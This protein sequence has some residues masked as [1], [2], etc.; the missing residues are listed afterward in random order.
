[1]TDWS[2]SYENIWRIKFKFLALTDRS[3]KNKNQDAENAG[4]I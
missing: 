2:F 4:T 3:I 1:M